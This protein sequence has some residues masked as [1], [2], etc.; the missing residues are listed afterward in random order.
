VTRA[1]SAAGPLLALILILVLGFLIRAFPLTYSHFWDETVFLQNAMVIA[2][3]RTNYDEFNYRPP[4]LSLLYAAG[5]SF[6]NHIYV[7][8][9]VQGVLTSMVILFGFLFTRRAFGER[10]AFFAA[11]LFAFTPYLVGS[12]HSL[13]TGMPAVALMLCAMASFQRPGLRWA[14]LAGLAFALA[15]Q[16]RFTSLFLLGYFILYVVFTP[17]RLR[18]LGALVVAAALT[19]VP[20]LAWVQLRY[21]DFLQPFTHARDIVTKWN[22]PVPASFYLAALVE[23]YT[24][25]IALGLVVAAGLVVAR[26]IASWRSGVRLWTRLEGALRHQWVLF[27]WGAA[28]LLY[29]LSIPHKEVRYLLP[30]AIPVVVLSAIGL[31]YLVSRIRRDRAATSLLLGLLLAAGF[32]LGH[33]VVLERLAGPW[34]NDRRDPNVEVAGYLKEIS[35]AEDTIYAVTNFPVLAF[36]SGRTTR[37][38]LTIQEDFD[39]QWRSHLSSKGYFVWYYMGEDFEDHSRH[40]EIQPTREFLDRHPEFVIQKSFGDIIVYRYLP[41]PE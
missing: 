27:G 26:T 21:G 30:T 18:D 32:M 1:R 35:T 6:W 20:Y 24:P 12:S 36:Y 2:E 4:L 3:G 33:L 23:I 13:L 40:E 34:I 11:L 7:A 5:F 41:S 37:S 14:V 15:V 25:L 28:F 39:A 19:M 16:M 38:T 29:M 17:K 8:N 9:L 10:P 31:D 22:A